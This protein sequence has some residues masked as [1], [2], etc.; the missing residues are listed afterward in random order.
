MALDTTFLEAPKILPRR[1]PFEPLKLLLLLLL[2]LL[3][4]PGDTAELIMMLGYP[5]ME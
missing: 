5:S 3:L 2:L 4:P 1:A